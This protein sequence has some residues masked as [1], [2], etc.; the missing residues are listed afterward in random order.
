[1]SLKKLKTLLV[2]GFAI[3]FLNSC[4]Y[5][6]VFIMAKEDKKTLSTWQNDQ[7]KVRIQTRIGWAGPRYYHCRV[8]AK[9]LGGLYYKTIVNRSFSRESYENCLLNYAYKSDTLAIDVCTKKIE[10]KQNL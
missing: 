5:V 2:I 1:M 3:S 8:K 4:M 9:K 7:Y 6:K 10:L